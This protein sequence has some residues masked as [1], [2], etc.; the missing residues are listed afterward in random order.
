MNALAINDQAQQIEQHHAAAHAAADK[1]IE[2]AKEAGRLLLEVK[3]ALPHGEFSKWVAER[4]TVSQRQAQR[5]MAAAQGKELVRSKTKSDT[6][7]F[8]TC[9]EDRSPAKTLAEIF[10]P[11]WVPMKG[12]SY[13]CATEG[14]AYWV[15]ESS[16]NPGYFHVSRL[17]GSEGDDEGGLYD[18]TRR[19]VLPV[20]VEATLKS[21]AL[22][23]PADAPW[24]V[25][26][27]G[28]TERPFGEP[29]A[30]KARHW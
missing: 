13:V 26:K 17:Y 27:G 2:H 24:E 11:E 14:G 16:A 25:C 28:A 7:S 4:L 6:V 30:A 3:A 9:N 10:A 18:G 8:L 29:E 20:A 12:Y 19:P 15:T 23:T 5:Y 1:A 21:F 22:D